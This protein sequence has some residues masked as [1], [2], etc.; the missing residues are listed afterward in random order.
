[1]L[2]RTDKVQYLKGVGE[3]RAAQL[4]K[5]GIVTVEG[6]AAQLSADYIDYSNPCGVLE[7]PYETPC[8]VRATVFSRQ[9]PVRVRGRENDLPGQCGG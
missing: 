6:P 1:M 7:A 4:S 2:K 5:L 9:A 8:V 3:K